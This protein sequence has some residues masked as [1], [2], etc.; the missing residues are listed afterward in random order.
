[1]DGQVIVSH[2]LEQAVAHQTVSPSYEYPL[3]AWLL[4]ILTIY[5]GDESSFDSHEVLSIPG[6]VVLTSIIVNAIGL[7][8][9]ATSLVL[10][11]R[12]F[13]R[14]SFHSNYYYNK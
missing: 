12:A 1:M 6:A 14:I 10:V 9:N 5:S 7:D 4:L 2:L 8:I 13:G 11:L 3:S